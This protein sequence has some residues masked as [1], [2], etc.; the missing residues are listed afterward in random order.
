MPTDSSNNIK[1]YVLD[2]DAEGHTPPHP[3]PVECHIALMRRLQ[4]QLPFS[5]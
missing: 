2:P 3:L 4:V 5:L 1:W